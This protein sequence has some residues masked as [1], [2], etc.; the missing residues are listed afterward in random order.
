MLVPDP[1]RAPVPRCAANACVPVIE[2]A[3]ISRACAS[4]RSEGIF[5][6]VRM[7]ELSGERFARVSYA[8]GSLLQPRIPSV[9]DHLPVRAETVEEVLGCRVGDLH[10]LDARHL[11]LL[12]ELGTLPALPLLIEC[13]APCAEDLFCG[14]QLP[15]GISA[16]KTGSRIEANTWSGIPRLRGGGHVGS[17]FESIRCHGRGRGAAMHRRWPAT[18]RRTRPFSTVAPSESSLV[19]SLLRVWG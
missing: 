6:S 10:G 4:L 7:T 9:A 14:C 15:R 5:L 3:P 16:S 1:H 11:R 8:Q 13:K 17:T 12:V 2:C 19:S 18:F